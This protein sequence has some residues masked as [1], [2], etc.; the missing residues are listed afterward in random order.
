MFA[1]I[2]SYRQQGGCPLFAVCVGIIGHTTCEGMG[3]V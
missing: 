3:D 1:D 2:L